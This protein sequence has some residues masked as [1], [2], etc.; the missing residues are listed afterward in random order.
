MEIE[1]TKVELSSGIFLKWSYTHSEDGRKTKI[2][3]SADA[4]VH[5]DLADA[6]QGLVPHFVLLTEMKKKPDVVKDIDLKSL[7]EDLTSKYKVKGISI[8]DKKGDTHYKISGFKILNTGK[9]VSFES[10]TVKSQATEENKYEFLQELMD[11]VEIIKEEVLEYMNG[12][13][14]IREQTT[15]DFGEEFDPNEETEEVG[16]FEETAA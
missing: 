2:S 1:I 7:S 6:L 14:A 5:E 13:C 3:A 15:M 12:K 8:E 10:P 4:L 16:N 11:Q 9:T